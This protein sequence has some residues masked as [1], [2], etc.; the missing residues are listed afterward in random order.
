MWRNVCGC[1]PHSDGLLFEIGASALPTGL[2]ITVFYQFNQPFVARFFGLG[3][4]LLFF[5]HNYH[6]I[7]THI[8]TNG[9][10]SSFP[11]FFLLLGLEQQTTTVI[12]ML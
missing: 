11:R 7:P 3:A 12:T 2:V 1:L 9:L 5:S 10:F 4:K 8:P 6:F